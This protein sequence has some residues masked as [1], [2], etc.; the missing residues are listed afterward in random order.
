MLTFIINILSLIISVFLVG[1]MIFN[2]VRCAN[3]H[4]GYPGQGRKYAL[5]VILSILGIVF[6]MLIKY[7]C[8][9]Y[10]YK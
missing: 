2:I 10:I 7:L 8:T 5:Y 1:V 4:T 6:T 9:I 3:A